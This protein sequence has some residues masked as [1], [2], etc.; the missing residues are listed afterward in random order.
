LH[1]PTLRRTKQGTKKGPTVAGRAVE[2]LGED[3]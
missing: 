1:N 2:V 3:A